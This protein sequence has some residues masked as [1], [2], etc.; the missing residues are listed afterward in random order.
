VNGYP[1]KKKNVLL[2]VIDC[3]RADFVY[4]P[5]VPNIP[6]LTNLRKRGYSFL[7]TI[8]STTTTTPSFASILTGL[9]PFENGARSLAGYTLSKDVTTLPE[10]LKENG[11]NTYAEVTGPLR[12]EV[13]LVRGFDEYNFRN[14]HRKFIREWGEHLIAKFQGHFK[15]PWFTLLHLW[16]MHTPRCFDKRFD[17]MVY[18]ESRYEKALAT[19]DHYLGRLLD[20]FDEDALIIITGDHGEMMSHSNVNTIVKVRAKEL[21]KF[22][23]RKKIID[24]PTSKFLR[25]YHIEHGHGSSIY[26]PLVKVPLILYNRE[27]I[28]PG[29]SQTQIRQIDIF[30]TVL[31]MIGIKNPSDITG[32]SLVPIMRGKDSTHRDAYMEA[33]GKSIPDRKDWLA[34][35]RVDNGYKF[36]YSPFRKDFE[37]ELYD[38]KNDPI[39]R[40]NIATE[41]PKLINDLKKRINEIKRTERI[42]EK[43]D[44][45]DQKVLLERLKDLGYVD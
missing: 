4:T 18:G 25:K 33:M 19:I 17:S 39:E 36:I 7:N 6:N 10:I 12:K 40:K 1:M 21:F 15:E 3:L 28:E 5:N 37:D 45:E 34:G 16:E 13:N 42:G 31:D 43:L 26:D 38:L 35:L 27:L 20:R 23:K 41:N 44:P 22:L 14:R 8:A 11:Y 9:Y 29:E 30:P 24:I 2:I 32:K